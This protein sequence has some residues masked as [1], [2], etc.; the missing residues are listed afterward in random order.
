MARVH[1]CSTPGC[2]NLA[3]CPKHAR[4]TSQPWSKDRDR[5]TQHT[6]RTL[7]L[8]RDGYTCRRCGLRDP[9]GR[10]L[11]AHHVTSSKGMTLCNSKG[12]SCHSAVDNHAR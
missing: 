9:T 7:T 5:Q 3:P 10:K 11:D 8:R 1:V 4:P 2:P 6:F 12:N